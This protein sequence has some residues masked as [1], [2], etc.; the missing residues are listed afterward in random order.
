MLRAARVLG[1][2]RIALG[3]IGGG[4]L[5]AVRS[6][7]GRG[8]GDGGADAGQQG[9]TKSGGSKFG[10]KHFNFHFKFVMDR[11]VVRSGGD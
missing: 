11:E 2:T 5:D 10:F 8:H 6:G 1:C 9:Q 7:L 3:A 4:Q